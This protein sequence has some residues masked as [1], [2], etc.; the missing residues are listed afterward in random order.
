MKKVCFFLIFLRYF[1]L[2]G[3]YEKNHLAH[4]PVYPP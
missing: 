1:E 4:N 3:I 2:G